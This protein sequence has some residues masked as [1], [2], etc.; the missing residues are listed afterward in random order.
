M[1]DICLSAEETLQLTPRDMQAA[2]N[3]G[4]DPFTSRLVDQVTIDQWSDG[5]YGQLYDAPEESKDFTSAYQAAFKKWK[6]DLVDTD[7]SAWRFCSKCAGNVRQFSAHG[8]RVKRSAAEIRGQQT[9]NEL[10]FGSVVT[11]PKRK[12]W[13]FWEI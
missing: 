3:A 1:C 13:R 7:S 6:R 5:L 8:S 11:P 10:V 9:V 4:F 12:W 2:V